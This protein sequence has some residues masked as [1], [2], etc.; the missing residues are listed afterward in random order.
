MPLYRRDKEWGFLALAIFVS[1]DISSEALREAISPRQ[2]RQQ[3]GNAWLLADT[4]PVRT[5]R[6]ALIQQR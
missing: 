4:A 1:S 3:A 6:H 2:R 5:W